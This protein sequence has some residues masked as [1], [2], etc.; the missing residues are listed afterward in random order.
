MPTIPL[1]LEL[2]KNLKQYAEL[3]ADRRTFTTLV[4]ASFPAYWLEGHKT[5]CN[6]DEITQLGYH[7]SYVRKCIIDTEGVRH[8]VQLHWIYCPR[9]KRTWNIYPS[10]L[11]LDKRHDSYV[12][13]NLLEANLSH[14]MSYRG[15]LRQQP[16]LTSSGQA[17][18]NRLMDAHTIWLWVNWLGQWSLPQVL[19]A[20]GL[21]PPLYAVEDEKFP[22]QNGQKSYAVG[23][24]DQH[25]DLLWWL[26]Y[27][28]A[29]D[30]A[31]L[32]TSFSNL[33]NQLQKADPY[34]YF[35]GIT[36]DDWP[37]AKNAFQ[38]LNSKTTLA[39]CLLHPMQKV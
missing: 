36:G 17:R 33:Q 21:L 9:C 39:Q 23:L 22:T 26:D 15:A 18:P 34:H 11:V 12:V 20:C 14:E 3:V 1:I 35:W 6:I 24:V 29:T 30:E 8:Q 13:Q 27:V 7:G 38:A 4:N 31:T 2:G 16:Q 37:A 25:Y 19:L 28:F 32:K 5:A 10:I